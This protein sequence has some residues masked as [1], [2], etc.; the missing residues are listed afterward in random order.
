MPGAG[1]HVLGIEPAN[2]LVEGRA[3]ERERGTLVILE[4]GEQRTYELQL[5][6]E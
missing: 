3:V 4:P 5:S 2:C 6:I 1:V